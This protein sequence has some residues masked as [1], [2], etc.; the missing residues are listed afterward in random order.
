MQRRVQVNQHVAATYQIHFA[1]RRIADDVVR[2]K[3]DHIPDNMAHPKLVEVNKKWKIFRNIEQSRP[4]GLENFATLTSRRNLTPL[5]PSYARELS[6]KLAMSHTIIEVLNETFLEEFGYAAVYIDENFDVIHA[7]GDYTKFLT[8]PNKVLTMNLL[9]MVPAD[10]ALNLGSLLRRAAR[11]KEK[12]HLNKVLIRSKDTVRQLDLIIK[13]YLDDKRLPQ[14][15]IL[16]LFRETEPGPLT[17]ADPEKYWYENQNEGRVTELE[18]ELQHL[19]DDLQAIMEELETANEELQSTNEELLSSNE[20][21]QSTNEELQSLNEE[22]HTINAEHVYKIRILTELDN[23]LN[24]YFRSTNISQI[25][26]DRK[27][28]IRKYTPAATRQINLIESDIGRSI[29]QISNNL[30]Y[31][32]LIDDIRQVIAKTTAIEKEVQDKEGVW[33]R[34]RVMPYITQE[35][36]VDGAIVIFINIHELKNLYFLRSG[37]LDSST[38]IIQAFQTLRNEADE[39]IDFTWT[40]VN[41]KA[42][43]Y[44][45]RPEADLLGKRLRREFPGSLRIDLFHQL[46]TVVTTGQIL[47]TEIEQHLDTQAYWFHLVAVKLGDGVVLNLEDITARKQAEQQLLRQAEEI[48]ASAERFRLISEAIPLPTYT[49]LP[50]GYINSF[51]QN[52]HQ[53]TGLTLEQSEGWGWTQV[54]HPDIRDSV[55]NAYHQ[56]IKTGNTFRVETLMRRHDGAYRWH[57]N[58]AVPLRNEEEAISMWIGTATDIHEQK[59]LIQ[60][61]EENR[62]FIRQI[63]ETSPDF[64]YV[65]DL[66][67]K[68]NVFLNQFSGNVGL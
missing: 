62:H 12:L 10:M 50:D 7:A 36:K 13:P 20:E 14:K 40:L 22:L 23:D 34:M 48:R 37:I 6:P 65:F 49:S 51:N 67:D 61:L 42:Q 35:G 8:L 66:V 1:E 16:V 38:N 2:G 5:P 19:K 60:E 9:K 28:M 33:F 4:L 52:W 3:N 68:K 32:E 17:I 39:I 15:F 44:L 47:D 31:D 45:Q 11:D 26:L 57:I 27:L 18:T 56:A 46:V 21:L 53:Y 24:N 54:I 43:D 63:T 30:N 59:M 58:Y 55:V 29:Y 64:I 41:L 25:F